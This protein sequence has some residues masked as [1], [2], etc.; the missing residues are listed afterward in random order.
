MALLTLGILLIL[1][2]IVLS[3]TNAFGFAGL[4]GS[5]VWLGWICI[6]LGIVLAIL[7]LFTRRRVGTT[8]V[9]RRRYREL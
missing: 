5:L 1:I 2:G 8:V 9:E 4:A 7:H 3:F 6:G